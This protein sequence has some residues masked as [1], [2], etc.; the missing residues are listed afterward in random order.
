MAAGQCLVYSPCEGDHCE[1][2]QVGCTAKDNPGP[3]GASC[4]ADAAFGSAP[5]TVHWIC[6]N[7]YDETGAHIDIYGPEDAPSGTIC[8]TVHRYGN[9]L[10]L[11]LR[12]HI[13]HLVAF[14]TEFV[15]LINKSKY[16]GV[17]LLTI[18]KMMLMLTPTNPKMTLSTET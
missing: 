6:I 9:N 5:G 12:S 16:L 17:Q 8:M 3:A 10:I 7:P 18:M 13:S 4:K 15:L 14:V 2:G 1:S 11:V